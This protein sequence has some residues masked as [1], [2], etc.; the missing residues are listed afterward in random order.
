MNMKEALTIGKLAKASGVNVETIRF[1]ERK[2]I[3]QQP[4]K[5]GAFRSYPEDYIAKVQFIKRSQE[6]GFTLKEAKELLDLK[7]KSQ[8]KCSDV[9]AKT[10]LKISEINQKIKDLKNMK[11]SL[12]GLANCCEDR[13]L[14]ISE[15][16]ILDCFMVRKE[17]S[18]KGD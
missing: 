11:R 8:A 16:P 7:I 1:Y 2:S 15:C 18:K 13:S 3:L 9:L 4:I 12:E 10:E 14:P 5:Q 17:S 6:L